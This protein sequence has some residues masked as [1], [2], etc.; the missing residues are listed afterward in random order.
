MEV[1]K[2]V[3][4]FAEEMERILQQNDFK[5]GWKREDLSYLDEKLLEEVAEYLTINRSSLEIIQ[6]FVNKIAQVKG[7]TDKPDKELV[8]IANICM[9][10]HDKLL[11]VNGN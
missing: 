11:N 2:N 6:T 4:D 10:L 3:E 1:R 5:G 8:D 7:H 9:M